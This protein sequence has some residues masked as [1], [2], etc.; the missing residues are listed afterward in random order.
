M[1]RKIVSPLLQTFILISKGYSIMDFEFLKMCY[2]F[3]SD[4]ICLVQGNCTI[5]EWN[6]ELQIT[7][8]LQFVD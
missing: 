2:T 4:F 8:V 7:V 5:S 3:L 1:W 6:Y